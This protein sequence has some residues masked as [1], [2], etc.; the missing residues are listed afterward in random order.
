[1]QR[2]ENNLIRNI[3]GSGKIKKV[4]PPSKQADAAAKENPHDR[5][6]RR[7]REDNATGRK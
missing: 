2:Q 5:I 7:L 1:M 3:D 6:L 4:T